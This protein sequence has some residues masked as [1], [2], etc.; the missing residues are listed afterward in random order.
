MASALAAGGSR[1]TVSIYANR[2]DLR[3]AKI[4]V[5]CE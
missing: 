4:S 3:M 2:I 5:E 1:V